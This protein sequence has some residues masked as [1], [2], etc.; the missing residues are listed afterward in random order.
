MCPVPTRCPAYR[1]CSLTCPCFLNSL[2]YTMF[3]VCGDLCTHCVYVCTYVWKGVHTQRSEGNSD[4]PPLSLAVPTPSSSPA[5]VTDAYYC[6]SLNVG[7]EHQTGILEFAQQPPHPDVHNI[8]TQELS[9]GWLTQRLSGKH[10]N[11]LC[12]NKCWDIMF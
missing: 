10:Q 1:R 7:L 11:F 8:P 4:F 5:L 2:I 12:D 9:P 6:A 3:I